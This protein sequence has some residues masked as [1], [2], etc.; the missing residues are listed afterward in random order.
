MLYSTIGENLSLVL[1]SQSSNDAQHGMTGY[2]QEKID[3]LR[4]EI[5]RREG[6]L[7]RTQAE[8]TKLGRELDEFQ[9]RYDRIVGVA[10]TRLDAVKAAIEELNEERRLNQIGDTNPLRSSWV[11]PDNYVSVEEQYRRAWTKPDPSASSSPASSYVEDRADIVKRLY[12]DLARR[13]HP[14]LGTN[15]AERARRT[16][17]MNHI[18]EAYQ[19]QDLETLELVAAQKDAKDDSPLAALT[20]RQ[21][22]KTRDSLLDE[23][24][25]LKRERDTLNNSRMMRLK[26]DEKMAKMQ[27]RDMLRDL[28]QDIDAEYFRLMQKLDDLRRGSRY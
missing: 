21:L 24:E 4:E 12:R 6:E 26:A 3:Q 25:G 13:F 14:D 9:E 17:I 8:V 23:I 10:Q 22:R 1:Q 20:L 11:P 28:A 15:D 27:G 18:N 2:L 19:A 7:V 5:Q 16:E